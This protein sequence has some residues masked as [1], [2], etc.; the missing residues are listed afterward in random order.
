[1]NVLP[2]IL[3]AAGEEVYQDK[4]LDS[5]KALS[6]LA[7]DPIILSLPED[8]H[9]ITYFGMRKNV[10]DTQYML[11]EADI[12]HSDV[13]DVYRTKFVTDAL[14][15]IKK[16]NVSYL[17]AHEDDRIFMDSACFSLEREGEI[18]LYRVE[19]ACIE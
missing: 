16:Y 7:K 1:M 8:G 4:Y 15:V 9:L 5:F 13:M 2:G 19:E 10:I 14:R 11:V 6:S 12:R 18:L 17:I 3:A